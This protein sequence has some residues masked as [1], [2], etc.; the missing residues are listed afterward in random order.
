LRIPGEVDWR[1]PSLT[2]PIANPA[3]AIDDLVN[4]ESV[5]LFV[6]RGR[7]VRTEFGVTKQNASA[8]VQ[9]CRRLDGIPL[10]IELAATHV[11]A[12][13]VEQIAA[14]L[15]HRFRLLTVGSR[16]AL[17]RHQTLAALIGWS[18]DRLSEAEQS[19][20]NRLTVFA[21]GFTLEAAEA[22]SPESA[23]A[24]AALSELVRKSMV[25]ADGDT[26]GVERYHL[27]ETLRQYG[28]E[29]L[30]AL[31]EEASSQQRHAAYYLQLAE[32]ARPHLF[33]PEQLVYLAWLD[34][35]WDNVRVAF[36]WFIDHQE[37]EAGMRLGTALEF[38]YWY[39]VI[40]EPQWYAWRTQLLALPSTGAPTAARANTLMWAGS[41]TINRHDLPRARQLFT[42]A[43][44]TARQAGDERMLAWVMHRTSRYG[45][46]DQEQWYGASALELAKGAVDFYQAI[47]DRWGTAITQTWLGY[48]E[49]Y[50]GQAEHGRVLLAESLAIARAV[51][52]RHCI[53]FALRC[54]GEVT[55]AASAAEAEGYLSESLLLYSEL[56]D[57]QGMAYVELLFG[58]LD[59]L[60]GR[61]N[62]A[63]RHYQAS[64][65][66]YNDTNVAEMIGQ[67][68]LGLAKL[69][70]GKGD[71]ERALRLAAAG[72]HVGDPISQPAYAIRLAEVEQALAPARE[73]LGEGSAAMVWAEGQA[74]TQ[75]VAVA[76]ALADGG[77]ATEA[78]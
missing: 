14:R 67:C 59:Y 68:L 4:F 37:A 45:G 22:V 13:P 6:E 11:S 65:R 7:A 69:A 62:S 46:P 42:Q 28:R 70:A 61:C 30:V 25:L 48:L 51:G 76:Y 72:A 32:E 64:L 60:N 49:H 44:T 9:I 40:D 56:G 29:R 39:R 26:G 53:A 55:S 74:M 33:Q 17:P 20:F 21:G 34:R 1:V 52:E 10:A 43:L 16:V 66:L 8:I 63:H 24:L 35:E 71:A 12:L 54:L 41:G 23:N 36:R 18:Y 19:L 38:W 31:G 78:T 27:L 73:S 5:R 47:G 3:T 77:A 57:V 58:R 50:R 2:V 75:E 15:D